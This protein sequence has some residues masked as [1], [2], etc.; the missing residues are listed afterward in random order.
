VDLGLGGRAYLVTGATGSLGSAIV[1]RLAA[2]GAVPLVHH[3]S[4]GEAAE[5]LAEEV[6]GQAFQADLRS[7]VETR[8]LLAAA[9]ARMGVLH[10]VVANAGWWPGPPVPVSDLSLDR[11]RETLERN[12][13]IT[14]STAGAYLRHVREVGHG[15]LVLM[16]SA[17]ADF[18]E[19][20][21]GD[22]A[23]A[24]SAIAYGLAR[25]LAREMVIAA[26]AA[27]VNVVSPSW[28]PSSA[29]AAA[30]TAA[31]LE[32]AL[33][34]VPLGRAASAEDVA[35]AVVW[36]LSDRASY[37]TGEVVHVT[38][39]MQGRVIGGRLRG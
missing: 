14:V 17:A 4:Q 23:A 6:G 36:L 30:R 25:T 11:V 10:G 27:R 13:T 32:E 22:Y 34:T 8:A 1:H 19:E 5:A 18:G 24:K 38:G 20:G 39:G 35:A 28:V 16:G 9:V 29:S 33:L 31:R 2:E 7:Q 3:R 21:Y 12:L 15:S 37:T 26:P